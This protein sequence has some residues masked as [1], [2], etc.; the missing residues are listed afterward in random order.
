[1]FH[2]G[3]HFAVAPNAQMSFGKRAAGLEDGG[4]FFPFLAT[5]LHTAIAQFLV[6]AHGGVIDKVNPKFGSAAIRYT[7]P[8]G[9]AVFLATFYTHAKETVVLNHGMLVAVSRGCQA[10]IMRV[11]VEWTIILQGHLAGDVPTGI[12]VGELERA[13]LHQ[14]A[15]QTAIG[16][17]VDVLEKDAVHGGGDRTSHLGGVHVKRG[18]L[19]CQACSRHHCCTNRKDSFHKLVVS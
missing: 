2:V 11:F 4:V 9:E 10:Y 8:H 13:V 18:C 7:C 5:D 1:M 15:I 14:L 12:V 3:G 6:V 16:S 19:C 17:I